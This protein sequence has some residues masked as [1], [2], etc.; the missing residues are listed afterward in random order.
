LP[1]QTKASS[2]R[3][4]YLTRTLLYNYDTAKR[5]NP[6]YNGPDRPF[7]GHPIAE[8]EG[9]IL[10]GFGDGDEAARLKQGRIWGGGKTKIDRPFY[11]AVNQDKPPVSIAVRIAE[12]VNETMYGPNRGPL[13]ELA[14]PKSNQVVLLNVP[15]QYRLNLPRYL[16]VVRLIPFNGPPAPGSVY[17]R[18][19]E[20]DLADP[21]HTVTAALRL[22]ALGSN[23]IEPLKRGLKH[24]HALVRF[25]S[26]EALAYLGCSACGEELANLVDAQPSLRSYCLTAMASL[27]ESV[28]HVKLRELLSS[29]SPET[30]YGA[31]R[32]LRA[33]DEHDPAIRGELLNDSFWLHRVAPGSPSLVHVSRSRRAEIVLFGEQVELSPPFSFLAGEFTVTAER[34]ATRCTISRLSLKR[35]AKRQQCSLDLEDLVRALADLG[36]TYSEVDEVLAQA[37]KCE[38]LSC[39][40]EVDALPQAT[41]VFELAEN[42]AN[43]LDFQDADARVFQR[44]VDLGATPNLF[45]KNASRKPKFR[46]EDDGRSAHSDH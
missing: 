42:G 46:R 4:G 23:A 29:P 25:S 22:E 10:V 18:R 36:A 27:D 34:G 33:L 37:K 44:T 41:S 6:N 11:L 13:P 15:P 32:A 21:Q 17:R 14:S 19:L 8:A 45:E 5:L 3:G 40:M 35:G 16:R 7:K 43:D 39:A 28:C 20:R 1:P 9:P 12:R 26:A 38:T 24:E 2:L 30:R 31:F